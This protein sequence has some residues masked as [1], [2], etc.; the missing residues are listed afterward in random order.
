MRILVHVCCGPC[1]IAVLEQLLAQGHDITAFFHNPN[2]QPLAEY[3]RRREGAE[4]VAQHYGVPIIFSDMFACEEGTSGDPHLDSLPSSVNPVMWLHKVH[5]KEGARC[6]LCWEMRIEETA[7]YAKE[8]G[9]DAITT[10]LLYSR[11]QNHE[12]LQFLG[13][14]IAK[15]NNLLLVYED[16]RV[17]WQH[18]ID[19]SKELGIYRQPYC[20]CMFSEYA[21]YGKN[22]KKVIKKETS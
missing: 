10:S 18:G 21:R 4:Q 3:L 5:G 15:E 12:K 1:S 8:H 7:L 19:L 20:G 22:L 16:F 9:F 14:K 17:F 13:E 11:Y 6:E 2:I